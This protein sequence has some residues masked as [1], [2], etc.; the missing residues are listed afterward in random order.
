VLDELPEGARAGRRAQPNQ[1]GRGLGLT[2]EIA[3]PLSKDA[4]VLLVHDDGETHVEP[5]S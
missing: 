4:E 3:S 2:G 5:L 1:R